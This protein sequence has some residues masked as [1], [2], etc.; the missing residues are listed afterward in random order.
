MPLLP[1]DPKELP[2]IKLMAMDVMN[3]QYSTNDSAMMGIE[4]GINEYYS[5]SYEEIY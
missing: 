2:E 5:S 1:D 3:R 4:N